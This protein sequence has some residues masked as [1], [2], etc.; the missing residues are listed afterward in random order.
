LDSNIIARLIF[1]LLPRQEKLILSI[2]RTYWKFGQ[3]DINILMLGVVYN[4]VAFPLI[5][6][7]LNKRGNSNSQ[8]RIDLVNRFI[9]LFGKDAIESIVADREF[10]GE[11]GLGFLNSE[12]LRYCIRIRL[13]CKVFLPTKITR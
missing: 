9:R 2:D 6:S 10:I 8:E 5:F 13:N 7:M 11:K 12:D 3:T 4:G 1:A